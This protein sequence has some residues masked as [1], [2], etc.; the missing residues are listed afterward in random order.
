MA[1]IWHVAAQQ[2]GC[3]AKYECV[4]CWQRGREEGARWLFVS[5]QADGGSL[6]GK[7]TVPGS[8]AVDVSRSRHFCCNVI[9]LF[10]RQAG[11]SLG[12]QLRFI[13]SIFGGE[14]ALSLIS[15]RWYPRPD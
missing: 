3:R 5:R 4:A 2:G 11:V 7:K 13:R 14:P 10:I 8:C 9:L 12:T 1:A 15:V 6:G